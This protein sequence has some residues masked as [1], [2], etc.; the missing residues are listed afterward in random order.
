MR[1]FAGVVDRGREAVRSLDV[2]VIAG[3]WSALETRRMDRG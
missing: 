1:T 2:R 3:K